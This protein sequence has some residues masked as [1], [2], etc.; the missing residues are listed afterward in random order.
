MPVHQLLFIHLP[1]YLSTS[2]YIIST[3]ICHF[4]SLHPHS[5]SLVPT[6]LCYAYAYAYA[7]AHAY[8]WLL[9][10]VNTPGSR[11]TKVFA[12][13][14]FS[15]LC[16]AF[17]ISLYDYYKNCSYFFM[18]SPLHVIVVYDLILPT[19]QEWKSKWMKWN[20]MKAKYAF[21]KYFVRTT[22]STRHQ[23]AIVS[24]LYYFSIFSCYIT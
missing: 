13:L 20:E 24:F 4:T 2:T 18:F 6:Y 7:Y 1:T 19:W 21:H 17:F 11:S 10:Y 12:F 23:C 15:L 3:P 9:C 16:F 8:L 14:F 5:H 22:Y